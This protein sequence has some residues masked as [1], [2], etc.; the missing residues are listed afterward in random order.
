MEMSEKVVDRPEQNR[1]ELA[2]DGGTA[3]AA[4]LREGNTFVFTHTEVPEALEGQGI[5]SA[6][7]KGALAHVRAVG[8]RFVP[9]CPFVAAYA[10]RHP[11]VR[12]LLAG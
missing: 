12:D 2:V 7:I 9:Q 5:G 4:Y 6:L 3:I 10:D 11:E 8:D 1:F